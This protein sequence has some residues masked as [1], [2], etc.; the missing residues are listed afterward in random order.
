M[1]VVGSAPSRSESGSAWLLPHRTPNAHLP[2]PLPAPRKAT[3]SE[4]GR[5]VSSS[6][7]EGC[8]RTKEWAEQGRISC[9]QPSQ[10]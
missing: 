1:G 6:S 4:K 3:S 8:W 2:V 9:A 10:P 7:F 5:V